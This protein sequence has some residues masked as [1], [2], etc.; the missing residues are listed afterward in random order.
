MKSQN[1]KDKCGYF[2]YK[3]FIG[4]AVRDFHDREV[5]YKKD[6]GKRT[7]KKYVISAPTQSGKSSVKGI[8]QSLAKVLGIPTIVLT[9]G[10]TESIDLNEKLV[11]F[12]EGTTLKREHVVVGEYPMTLCV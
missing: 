9:K 3:D 2:D 8:L 5:S 12:A 7:G 6:G 11:E 10:V 1:L 4:K